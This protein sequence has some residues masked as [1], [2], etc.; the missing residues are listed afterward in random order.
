MNIMKKLNILILILVFSLLILPVRS[1]ASGN[2]SVN[3]NLPVEITDSNSIY[4]VWKVTGSD[5][6]LSV[7]DLNKSLVKLTEAELETKYGVSQDTDKPIDRITYVNNLEDGRYY[8]R[9]K[10]EFTSG[11]IV[12]FLI[13]LPVIEGSTTYNNVTAYPKTDT[14]EKEKG[15]L[16]ILKLGVS[17]T[18]KSPLKGVLF[19]LDMLDSNGNRVPVKTGLETDSTG[20]ILVTDLEPGEYFIIESKPLP[21]YVALSDQ[22]VNIIQGERTYITLENR[23]KPVGPPPPDIPDTGDTLQFLL[24]GSGILVSLGGFLIYTKKEKKNKE[25]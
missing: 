23:K 25:D 9:L 16:Q 4:K 5:L 21:G 22:K 19:D 6:T 20:V 7:N 11:K 24:M 17:G 13:D 1:F 12:Y 2:N 14:I 8:F 15:S 10:S 18:T 3:I